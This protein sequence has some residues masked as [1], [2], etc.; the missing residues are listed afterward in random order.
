MVDEWCRARGATKGAVV[1]I[2]SV[3]ELARASFSGRLSPDW[4]PRTVA[5]RRATLDSLGLTGPF[6]ELDPRATV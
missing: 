5:E 4:R 3:G 6:W 1:D 2:Q